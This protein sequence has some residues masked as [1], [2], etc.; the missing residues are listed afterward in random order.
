LFNALRRVPHDC[1]SEVAAHREP[2]EGKARRR[3]GEDARR[4]RIHAVVAGV[5]S[6]LHR[7]ESPQRGYLLRIE[8]RGTVQPG[9]EDHGDHLSHYKPRS[10]P[11]KIKPQFDLLHCSRIDFAPRMTMFR[12]NGSTATTRPSVSAQFSRSSVTRRG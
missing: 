10:K 9:N 4:D 3:G 2:G 6:H 7:P 11:E 1:Q 5:V 12:A 8:A